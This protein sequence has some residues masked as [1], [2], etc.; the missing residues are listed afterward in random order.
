MNVQMNLRKSCEW[1]TVG[2][3]EVGSMIG[4]AGVSGT[5]VPSGTTAQ[6]SFAGLWQLGREAAWVARQP[7][8][9]QPSPDGTDEDLTVLYRLQNGPRPASFQ[10][11][12]N[13]IL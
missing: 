4:R 9:S 5:G 6:L 7:A 8:T 1:S 2:T 12:D 11:L 3:N 13:G 10:L